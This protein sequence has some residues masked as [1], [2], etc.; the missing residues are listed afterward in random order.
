M[1]IREFLLEEMLKKATA[2]DDLNFGRI[3]G[4]IEI[5]AQQN[6]EKPQFEQSTA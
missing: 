1:N 4:I 5:L 6:E 2:L 3:W